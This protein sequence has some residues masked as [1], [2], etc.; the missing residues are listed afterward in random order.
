[1]CKSTLRSAGI[2]R[3]R[4]YPLGAQSDSAAVSYTR[5]CTALKRAVRRDGKRRDALLP[6]IQVDGENTSVIDAGHQVL[7]IVVR[8]YDLFP[9]LRSFRTPVPS[10]SIW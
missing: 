2:S 8:R 4:T 10:S 7:R 9:R 1:M 5:D 6:E 3:R